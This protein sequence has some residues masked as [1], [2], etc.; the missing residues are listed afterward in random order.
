[1]VTKLKRPRVVKSAEDR[2]RELLDAA[3]KVLAQ[4]GFGST[5]VADITKAAGVAKGTFYLYFDSKD[6]VV[7]ALRERFVQEL[8]EHAMPFVQR[9]GRVDWWTLAD[10]VVED[11]VDWTLARRDHISVLMQSYTP[12]THHLLW[13]ADRQIILLLAEG[14]QAGRDQGAFDVGDPELAAWFLYNGIIYTVV[15]QMLQPEPVDRDRLV[16]AARELG[17]KLLSAPSGG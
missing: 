7:A 4:R 9:I 11:M 1:M 3:V 2:R 14:L 12:E 16:A 17:R 6:H 8:T 5:T 13:E 15:Q 10:A